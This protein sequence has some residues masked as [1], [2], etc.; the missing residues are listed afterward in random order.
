[1][2]RHLDLFADTVDVGAFV[3]LD[4]DIIVPPGWLAELTKQS[5]LHPGIDC[6]GM[7]PRFGPA[8]PAPFAGRTTSDD[9]PWIGGVG[10]IRYR[11]FTTC[12]PSP[13]GRYGWSEFQGRHEQN[14]KA[15]LIP[16]LPLFAL[17]LIDA[18]P[19][20]SFS[21]RY[22]ECGWQRKWSKYEGGGREWSQWWLD[23]QEEKAA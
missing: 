13:K 6:L 15:W 17:D 22:E 1:M 18:E 19:W 5:Y 16:D 7:Q 4:N 23:E 12:R 8:Y 9:A 14:R 11:M 10:L 20:A 21:K 2:N 3:K